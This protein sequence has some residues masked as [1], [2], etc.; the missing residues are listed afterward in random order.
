MGG[1]LM[2]GAELRDRGDGRVG[3][4]KLMGG[5][6]DRINCWAGSRQMWGERSCCRTHIHRTQ[7]IWESG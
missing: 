1:E 6:R 7:D 3:R 5:L 4:G 2:V